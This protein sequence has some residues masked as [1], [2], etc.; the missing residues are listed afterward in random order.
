MSHVYAPYI[1]SKADEYYSRQVHEALCNVEQPYQVP[2]N[3]RTGET[4]DVYTVPRCNCWL[5]DNWEDLTLARKFEALRDLSR[6]FGLH[7]GACSRL[8]KTPITYRGKPETLR[9]A[10]DCWLS[11]DMRPASPVEYVHQPEEQRKDHTMTNPQILKDLTIAKSRAAAFNAAQNDINDFL[12]PFVR[13]YADL[14][15]ELNPNYD[16]RD[17][18]ADS[19]M[20]ID[21]NSF[22]LT[23]EEIYQYSEYYTPSL[24]LP[25]A[26]VEDPETY[27]QIALAEKAAAYEKAV[28]KKKAEAAERVT[29]LKAQLARAEAEASAA[30]VQ[31][32]EIKLTAN[33][34]RAKE[35]RS[36][37][38][39]Q[40]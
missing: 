29:R 7:S 28:T 36:Q 18:Q 9:Y 37:Y 1:E 31:K 10:C 20:E 19:F 40:G 6:R 26:F 30:E 2:F 17:L 32:D 3:N 33:R 21:N 23:G 16:Q 15:I 13:K 38:M 39:E 22:Y 5:S 14:M 11:V 8:K 27:R 25:F 34:N 24:N 12:A 35:L 4:Y